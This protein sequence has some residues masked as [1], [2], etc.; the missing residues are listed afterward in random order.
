MT[1][2]L[3]VRVQIDETGRLRDG[4][5]LHYATEARGNIR[6]TFLRV[7]PD[8][9]VDDVLAHGN[10]IGRVTRYNG[11]LGDLRKPWSRSSARCSRFLTI[12]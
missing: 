3:N 12:P 1:R 6:P 10:V 8:A 5:E 9:L 11:A 7:G 4:I 2:R